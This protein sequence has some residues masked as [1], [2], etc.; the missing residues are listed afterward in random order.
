MSD[1]RIPKDIAQEIIKQVMA[2]M[3]EALANQLA[4]RVELKKSQLLQMMST[5][6]N[7]ACDEYLDAL[8]KKADEIDKN[9]DSL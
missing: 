7:Q 8:K 6:L 2:S 9:M 4:N 1:E 3:N 5:Y